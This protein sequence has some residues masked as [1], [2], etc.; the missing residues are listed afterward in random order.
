IELADELRSKGYP[1]PTRVAATPSG[2][3]GL[4]W[5]EPPVYLEM[6]LVTPYRSEWVQI[7]E[8]MAPVHGVISKSPFIDPLM[9]GMPPAYWVNSVVQPTRRLTD[10]VEAG[11][12]LQPDIQAADRSIREGRDARGSHPEEQPR[13][14]PI[15]NFIK[16]TEYAWDEDYFVA[17]E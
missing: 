2:T 13:E 8:G 16:P 1:P 11:Q 14:Y 4:E 10:F 6:E 7:T 3:V 9:E 12:G 15:A 17:E 5:Q